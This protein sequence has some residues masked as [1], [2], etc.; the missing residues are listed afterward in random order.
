MT[1]LGWGFLMA[2]AMMGV[3]SGATAQTTP[4]EEGG[5]VHSM[6]HPPKIAPFGGLSVGI[7]GSEDGDDVVGYGTLGV[8]KDLVNPALRV[9]G[10][11]LEGYAGIRAE[12]LDGGL[13]AI[14]R[15]PVLRI[16]GGIDYNIRDE[17]WNGVFTF[18]HPLR[19]GGLIGNGSELRFDWI[20]GRSGSFNLG[21]TLPLFQPHIDETRPRK[22]HVSLRRERLPA[23][24]HSPDPALMAALENVRDTALWI[25]KLTT[26]FVDDKAFTSSGAQDAY[27]RHLDKLEAHLA[28]GR[29]V[30]DDVRAYHEQL[31]R[32]FD[33]ATPGRGEE[34]AREAKRRVLNEVVLPYN[35]LLGQAKKKDTTMSS[36]PGAFQRFQRFCEDAAGLDAREAEAA[37]FV[38]RELV[39]IVEA[40][41]RDLRQSWGESQSVWLPLQLVLLPEEHDSQTE[42]DELVARAT[43]AAFH[44]GNLVW[45]IVNEQFQLELRRSLHLAENYHVLWIHDIKAVNFAGEPDTVTYLQVVEGYLSAL[46]ERVEHYDASGR[47]PVYM[48]FQ[49]QIFYEMAGSRRVLEVLENPLDFEIPS[50]PEGFEHMAEGLARSRARLQKAVNTSA[51]LQH[52]RETYGERWLTNRLKVHVSI[53]NPADA[54]FFTWRMLPIVGSADTMIRDHRKIAFYD[55]TE[56]DPYKGRAIYSGMGVGEHY[57]GATW[58]DRAILA[59]GPALLDLKSSARD[60][61]LGQGWDE[62]E[63][64]HPLRP[65]VKPP[66]YDAMVRHRSEELGLRATRGMDLHNENAYGMKRLSVGKAA[67]Y[68]LMPK[69]STIVVPDHLWTARMWTSMVLGASLRGV[70][71]LAISPSVASHPAGG[72]GLIMARIYDVLTRFIVFQER[73]AE[74][75]DAAEGMVKVGIYDIDLD[76]KDIPGRVKMALQTLESNPFLQDLI[77]LDPGVTRMSGEIDEILSGFSWEQLVSAQE[78]ERPKLHMKMSFFASPEAWETLTRPELADAL[79]GYAQQWARQ[80]ADPRTYTNV[81]ELPD[82]LEDKVLRVVESNRR[83]LSDE[84][85]NRISAYLMVGSHNQDER[86]FFLDGDVSFVVSGRGAGQAFPDVLI[87]IGNSH[88]VETLDALHGFIPEPGNAWRF[89]GRFGRDVI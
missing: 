37:A 19:R 17:E 50:F 16:G 28:G 64:P 81:E 26:P 15:S 39:L 84:A 74:E 5:L 73:M 44:D 32:A 18:S 56:D 24:A 41:R 46:A 21:V 78:Y 3:A 2:S 88:W 89:L 51:K 61:L 10:V 65:K 70:R 83:S 77:R 62:S 47:L 76:V 14:I 79:A 23:S 6:G 82:Q 54:S 48:I 38:F 75:L 30:E 63:I 86:A 68:N 35:R 25:G 43:G 8:Y 80:V 40:V 7:V 45:Y 27:R 60:L 59:E 1:K 36:A 31:E 85:Q 57:V 58:E 29:V 42:L 55:V 34:M 20:S 13:R 67:L 53:T 11:S 87:M 9:L 66:G 52:E 22:D 12:Q 33:L 71:I 4:P 72:N 69:G 49:D